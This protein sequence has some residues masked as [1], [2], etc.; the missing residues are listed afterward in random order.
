MSS[1]IAIVDALRS[2]AA[3]KESI[4]L[5]TVVRVVGSSY[6][7]VGARM[8]IRVD[9]STVGLVSGGCLESDL[10]A[11]AI[12][13]HAT[14][15]ARV[16]TYDTRAD[17]DAV[18]G[19]GLGCNGLIDVLLLSLSPEQ[20]SLNAEMLGAAL[21]DNVPSVIATVVRSESRD[22]APGVGAQARFTHSGTT[23]IGDWGDGSSLSVARVRLDDALA[24]GRRGFACE[25]G[26]GEIAF[27]VVAPA[28]RLVICGAGPDAVPLCRLARGLGWDVDVIDHR[29]VTEAHA[30]RFPGVRV[31][32]C[33]EAS[34]LGGVVK[35]TPRTA[36]VAMSHHF[37]RDT[38]YVA[39]LLIAGVAYVGV[40]G[41]RART[42]RMLAELA[43]RGEKIPSSTDAL[44]GPVGL[45]LGGDGPEAIAL[46]AVAEI[47]AVMHDRVPSHL[48]DRHT[49]LHDP[50]RR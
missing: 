43:S 36:A 25:L 10:C 44:F 20:A 2:A 35:L 5:A 29:A 15:Q 11:H 24:A 23:S 40:L 9:G 4:V 12:E 42:E 34:G 50:A 47:S 31:R 7:G 26:G 33:P 16:V 32:E 30:V 3:G 21:S 46:A 14:G 48:R 17:D 13:V 37:A 38:N 18:W 6:G 39:A 45:D 27:E 19:L 22:G 49:A 1:H 41:P 28:I 8:I